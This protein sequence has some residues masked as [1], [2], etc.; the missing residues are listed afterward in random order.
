MK[1]KFY[2]SM[3]II[4]F[5]AGLT[6]SLP[7]TSVHAWGWRRTSITKFTVDPTQGGMIGPPL[8]TPLG[9]VGDCI[10]EKHEFVWENVASDARATVFNHNTLFWL[11]KEPFMDGVCWGSR[12]VRAS[13][14]PDDSI[15]GHGY[16][17]GYVKD[18][19]FTWKSV[20][21]FDGYKMV[22]WSSAPMMGLMNARGIIIE[23]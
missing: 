7:V 10:Y 13:A 1:T 18:G 8:V 14:S 2:T 20:D 3:I 12:D 5:V 11:W 23:I 16:I 9:M 22:T 19:I 17:A 21:Y 6:L 4:L 15:I